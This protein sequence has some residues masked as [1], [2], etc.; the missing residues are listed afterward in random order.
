MFVFISSFILHENPRQ[1][2]RHM[3]RRPIAAGTASNPGAHLPYV[4]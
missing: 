1:G 3:L 4:L 2:V